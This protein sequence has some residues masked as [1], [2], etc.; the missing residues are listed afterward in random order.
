MFCFVQSTKALSNKKRA[1]KMLMKLTTGR[2]R[3]NW[4]FALSFKINDGRED[5]GEGIDR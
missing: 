5:Q 1:C 4:M 3:W 2:K